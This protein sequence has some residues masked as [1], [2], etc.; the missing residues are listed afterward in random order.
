MAASYRLPSH[1]RRRSPQARERPCGR[2]EG[3]P[4]YLR[5]NRNARLLGVLPDAVRRRILDADG[6]R[7][8]LL[9]PIQPRVSLA[10]APDDGRS[11]GQFRRCRE[12]AVMRSK[13]ATL[14]VERSRRMEGWASWLCDWRGPVLSQ[15]NRPSSLRAGAHLARVVL[16]VIGCEGIELCYFKVQF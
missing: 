14:V 3:A 8:S 16:R 2:Q 6:A 1:S 9:R 4:P 12:T 11:Q 10:T 7:P 15:P 5:G 13:V